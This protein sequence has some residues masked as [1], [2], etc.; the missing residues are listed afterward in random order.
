MP[1]SQ[2][3]TQTQPPVL[4]SLPADFPLRALR[5]YVAKREAMDMDAGEVSSTPPRRPHGAYSPL[6]LT[7]IVRLARAIAAMSDPT[8]LCPGTVAILRCDPG[9]SDPA[10]RFE[11][12]VF[13]A[14]CEAI[15]REAPWAG[16]Y[17]NALLETRSAD[18]SHLGLEEAASLEHALLIGATVIVQLPPEAEVPR[19]IRPLVLDQ[20]LILPALCRADIALMLRAC[21]TPVPGSLLNPSPSTP[22]D[23]SDLS[24]LH[25]AYAWAGE[26]A[27]DVFGRLDV[28]L[29][30]ISANGEGGMSEPSRPAQD[31]FSLRDLHGLR[32]ARA[33]LDRVIADVAAW[34]DGGLLWSEVGA[35][36]LLHGPPGVGKTSIAHAVAN[37]IGGEVIDLS[38][39]TVQAAGHLGKML[40][41]LDAGVAE[42]RKA[43]PCVVLVDE[44]DCLSD[45][46]DGTDLHGSSYRRSV[47]NAYLTRLTMLADCPGVVVILAT[48]YPD[49][50]DPAL[51]RAG[52]CDHHIGLQRPDR[53][54]LGRILRD[55]LGD[56][57]AEGIET[58]ITWAEALDNLAGGTGADAA[59]LAREAIAVAR[60]HLRGKSGSRVVTVEAD[61]LYAATQN[62]ARNGTVTPADLRR[63]AIHEAGH[64][65]LGHVLDRPAPIRAWIG[66][67]GAGI[68]SPCGRV[69]T[70]GTVKAELVSLLGGR[71]AEAVLCDS[72]S[73]GGGDGP[74]S[75][76]AQATRLASLAVGEWHLTQNDSP[77]VWQP[78]GQLLPSQTR[79]MRQLLA[80]AQVEA[81]RLV[82]IHAENITRIADVLMNERDVNAEQLQGLLGQ[83][84]HGDT[85]HVRLV[86]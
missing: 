29:D 33:Q 70:L 47:V 77:P 38:Y 78:P 11:R 56:R 75:D 18:P 60:A 19:D 14:F 30:H 57:V 21:G 43:A 13:P 73:S 49:Q 8:V 69:H 84:L 4:A 59:H 85:S 52:R 51:I 40:A 53:K 71:T 27:A 74:A 10:H 17:V 76:L 72:V 16:R 25:L 26:T 44:A 58:T 86:H 48:N 23:L 55:N 63:M 20:Q 68:S 15:Q 37:E 31:A 2:S 1:I 28:A 7:Q 36:F 66:P 67:Q 24:P 64:L 65:V 35:S 12:A 9:E 45:R 46:A 80:E 39:T 6:H 54:A 79:A 32:H 82:A 22:V 41:A 42:A 83:I 81:H 5:C 62:I 50:L 34:R 3:H 61:D